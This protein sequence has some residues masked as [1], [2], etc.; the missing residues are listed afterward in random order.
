MVIQAL[1]KNRSWVSGPGEVLQQEAGCAG[2]LQLCT[3][4]LGG[5]GGTPAQGPC[6][7]SGHQVLVQGPPEPTQILGTQ[8]EEGLSPPLHQLKV[9]DT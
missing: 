5:T 4:T 9:Q 1:L 7:L 8:W 3:W 6:A 2:Y